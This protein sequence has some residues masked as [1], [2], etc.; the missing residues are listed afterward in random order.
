MFQMRQTDSIPSF[1]DL[2][3]CSILIMALFLSVPSPSKASSCGYSFDVAVDERTQS[4][5][6][7]NGEDGLVVLKMN[8]DRTLARVGGVTTPG[9]ARNLCCRD[10]VVFVAEGEAGVASYQLSATDDP[11]LLGRIRTP[12]NAMSVDVTSGKVAAV[13][14]GE[15]GLCALDVSNPN[16]PAILGH[17]AIPGDAWDVKVSDSIAYVAAI[18][19]DLVLVDLSDPASPNVISTLPSKTGASEIVFVENTTAC[20]A[21]ASAGLAIFD[22]SDPGKPEEIAR[23]SPGE[24]GFVE[25]LYVEDPYAYIAFGGTHHNDG[26]R[27]ETGLRILDLGDRRSPAEVGRVDFP[28][29]VEGVWVHK[30][31]CLVANAHKGLRVID[32][33]DASR[34]LVLGLNEV[35]AD[36]DYDEGTILYETGKTLFR[37][38]EYSKAEEMLQASVRKRPKNNWCWYLLGRA[39]FENGDF[40]G[41]LEAF[42]HAIQTTESKSIPVYH[43]HKGLALALLGDSERAAAEF[44]H[45]RDLLNSE[46]E[47]R[48]FEYADSLEGKQPRSEAEVR[49]MVEEAIGKPP[50]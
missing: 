21:D 31:L 44:T 1:V 49:R 40:Q 26:S 48:S 33:S 43:Y 15:N 36:T 50:Q 27:F 10:G 19:Y 25:G 6:V 34:P 32:V 37:Q 39:R 45:V 8:S 2:R 35:C 28:E 16:Q 7:V 42:S 12:G 46:R 38:A 41:A 23:W 20:I 5:C 17:C 13:S 47:F 18:S 9:Y 11:E 30:G 24:Q 29:W 22:V 4:V 14:L 3:F